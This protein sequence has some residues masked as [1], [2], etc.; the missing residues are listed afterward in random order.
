[1]R[2][3]FSRKQPL[4]CLAR[5]KGSLAT[6]K[7]DSALRHSLHIRLI[8]LK[9]IPYEGPQA[10]TP[11]DCKNKTLKV[12]HAT[13]TGLAPTCD[14]DCIDSIVGI[15]RLEK[16]EN[17]R[18]VST[19]HKNHAGIVIKAPTL[20]FCNRDLEYLT[21]HP[22]TTPTVISTSATSPSLPDLAVRPNAPCIRAL[23][24][25]VSANTSESHN[26][27]RTCTAS[28]TITLGDASCGAGG[29]PE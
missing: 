14:T 1:M 26:S 9:R 5:P 24:H 7:L 13:A 2:G 4:I 28:V 15:E 8:R 10:P 11:P 16:G 3:T 17:T 25:R 23:A 20:S 19:N 21:A 18:W 27:L 6:C 12:T 29:R 22:L